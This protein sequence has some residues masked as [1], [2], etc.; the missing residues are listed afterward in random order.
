[1]TRKELM[2]AVYIQSIAA[3]DSS[4]VAYK[5]ACTAAEHYYS[6]FDE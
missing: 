4:A 6:L 2:C 1:M 3:G 5:K